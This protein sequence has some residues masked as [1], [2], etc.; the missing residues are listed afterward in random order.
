MLFSLFVYYNLMVHSSKTARVTTLVQENFF[1]Y[2]KKFIIDIDKTLI[3]TVFFKQHSTLDKNK[4]TMNTKMKK[5]RRKKRDKL[6]HW[7][8]NE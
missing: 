7:Q 6:V 3:R 8:L 5:K 2:S 1:V 4:K